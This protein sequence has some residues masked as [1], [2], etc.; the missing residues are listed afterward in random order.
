MAFAI[1]ATLKKFWFIDWRWSPSTQLLC[2]G[3][4]YY[5]DGWLSAD[6]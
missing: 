5:L 6:K 2:I 3:P 4:G 1:L